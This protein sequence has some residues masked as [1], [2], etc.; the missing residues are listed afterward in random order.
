MLFFKGDLVSFIFRDLRNET[1]TWIGR[2]EGTNRGLR[3]SSRAVVRGREVLVLR[4]SRGSGRV[5]A[6]ASPL[7]DVRRAA[8]P[9]RDWA[10]ER[11]A[12]VLTHHRLM[13]YL[14]STN[15]I[16]RRP[17]REKLL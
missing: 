16:T 8:R 13:E 6:G 17:S 12:C 11:R 4:V 7:R 2:G 3:R 15:W 9:E 14:S 5:A 1:G 10:C